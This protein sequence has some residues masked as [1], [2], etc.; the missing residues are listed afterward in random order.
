MMSAFFSAVSGLKSQ[1][2]GLNVIANNIS[3]V[4]TTGYKSSRVSFSDLLSQTLS[5]ASGS[6]ATTGG[7]N[8]IQIGLGVSVAS[9]DTN[10]TTGSTQATGVATDVAISGEGFF[11]VENGADGSYLYTRQGDMTVDEDGNLTVNGYKVCGWA[12]VNANGEI[13][14]TGDID[15]IN[16]YENNKKSMPASMTTAAAFSGTLDSTSTAHGTG[17][18]TIGTVPDT[19]DGTSSMTVYDAQGNAYSLTANWY[20][21]Y[22]DSSDADNPITSWYYEVSSSD[23]TITPSSGY[24][25]FDANGDIVDTATATTVSSA[26][27]TGYASAS[28]SY[29]AAAGNYTVTVTEPTTGNYVITLQDAAGNSYA[30]NTTST[31]NDAITFDLTGGGAFTLPATTALATGTTVFAVAAD[32]A[33]FTTT[34]TLTV[35]PDGTVGTAAFTVACDLGDI[36]TGNSTAGVTATPDGY[37]AG[38]LSG[39]AIEAD[40]TIVGTYSNGQT[41]DLAVISLAVFTN[42]EGLEKTGSNMY[43]A[44]SNSGTVSYYVAGQGGTSALSTGCL[45]MSN[46]DL[47]QEFSNMMIAQRA[48]QANSKVISTADEM[49]QS[50]ISMR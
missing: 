45:E 36:T 44:T 7:T 40:G 15:T 29:N 22:V 16:V 48:Y 28:A 4:N 42:D 20:K 50:L 43:A 35:T 47:A 32:T 23:A 25:A 5:S 8:P 2:T 34:P 14:T 31:T 3:N 1:T 12:T 11:V 46:V 49:L 33:S 19:A 41:Q 9:T 38:T 6:T 10:M 21:C 17:L 27:T 30:Y 26:G 39:I 18:T 37:A 13:I 24:I